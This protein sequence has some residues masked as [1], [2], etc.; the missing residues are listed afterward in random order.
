MS[1]LDKAKD[2]VNKASNA[3]TFASSLR[4]LNVPGGIVGVLSGAK[5]LFGGPGNSDD[6]RVRLSVPDNEVFAGSILSPLKRA[7]GLV[8]PFTPSMSISHTASYDDVGVMHQNYQFLAY[9]NSRADAITIS[10]TFVSEDA[11]QAQYWIA[12]VHFLRAATKMYTADTELQGSPPAIVTLNGY[13]DHVFKNVPVV[14]KNFSVE[15]PADVDYIATTVSDL[16]S[17]LSGVSDIADTVSN[18]TGFF[19]ADKIASAAAKVGAVAGTATSLAGRVTSLFGGQGVT[20]VPVKST[21]TVQVQPVYSRESIRQFSLQKF[22]KGEYI[23][24]SGGFI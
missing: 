3:A 15:M 5:V 4:S 8:F 12:A 18:I 9:Q 7:G 17:G 11:T 22:V 23:K 2:L 1:L 19:G 24:G 16:A 10:G 14:I 6:W 13:G 21:I 20:H